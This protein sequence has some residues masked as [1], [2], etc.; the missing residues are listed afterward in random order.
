M[1][2]STSIKEVA[3]TTEELEHV[4]GGIIV[5][6]GSPIFVNRFVSPLEKVSINPQPLPPRYLSLGFGH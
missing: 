6:G 2:D 4:V 5:I 3:L 1:T